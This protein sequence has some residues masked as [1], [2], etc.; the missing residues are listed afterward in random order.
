MFKNPKTLALAMI[1]TWGLMIPATSSQASETDALSDLLNKVDDLVCTAPKKINEFYNQKLVIMSDDKRILLENR[2]SDYEMMIGELE[3]IRCKFKRTVLAGN[4]GDKVAYL[5]VDELISVSSRASTDERQHSV[6]TYGFVKENNSWK[7]THEHCSSLP[8]YSIA[9][10]DD[11][12]Y[13]F[14]NPVY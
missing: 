1:L 10:G 2:V 7:I 3:E 14:H 13:Y 5:L 4:V 8:D 6:C 11:A 9:P 12:L